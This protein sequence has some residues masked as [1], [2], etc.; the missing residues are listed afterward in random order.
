MTFLQLPNIFV[1]CIECFNGRLMFEHILN[2]IQTLQQNGDKDD[3]FIRC[4]NMNDFIKMMKKLLTVENFGE[5]TLF[6]TID[7]CE[8]LRDM[9]LNLLPAFLR[10]NELT[11]CNICVLFVSDIVFEKFRQGTGVREPFQ[12]KFPDY[13]RKE[14]LEIM[15]LDAPKEHPPEFY[16]G[17]C[18]LLLSVF[19][20]VCRD[21]RE[22]RHLVR[23]WVYLIT[24]ICLVV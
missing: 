17:Y 15:C 8:R 13:S 12:V 19:Y 4:D 10:L 21:L 14:L 5:E 7:K 6:I 18:Q 1:N 24:V 2:N 11:G 16:N 3:E 23:V 20:N 22:L 9:E